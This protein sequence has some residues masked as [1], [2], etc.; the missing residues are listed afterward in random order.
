MAYHKAL[1]GSPIGRSPLACSMLSAV[2]NLRPPQPRYPFIW[3]VEKVLCHLKSLPANTN[4]SDKE[5]TLKLITMLALTA[6]SRCSEISYLNINFMAKTE[7]K[8]I[9]SFKKL[10]KV[11]RRSK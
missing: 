11:C 8:Y 4:L 1:H 9:F 7:G 3:D 10:T 2:F 5:L 6:T